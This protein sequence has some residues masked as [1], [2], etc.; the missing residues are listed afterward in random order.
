MQASQLDDFCRLVTQETSVAIILRI[1]VQ[2]SVGCRM[3]SQTC[4]SKEE[5]NDDPMRGS[6]PSCQDAAAA[7]DYGEGKGN[8]LAKSVHSHLYR[9]IPKT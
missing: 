4:V 7:I 2:E 8:L 5:G 3:M 6:R 1:T 9:A